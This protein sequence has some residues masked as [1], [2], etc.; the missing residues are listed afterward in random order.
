MNNKLSVICFSALFSCSL[1][2]HAKDSI[3]DQK[4]D[5]DTILL[6]ADELK[7]EGVEYT[8]EK[9]PVYGVIGVQAAACKINPQNKN[10][11]YVALASNQKDNPYGSFKY[12]FTIA[13]LDI[14]KQ[15]VVSSYISEIEEDATLR[16]DEGTLWIDT[17]NYRLNE[18]TRAF[19]VE[20][21]SGYIP[22]C[23]EGGL[24]PIRSL[25]LQ[26]G[27]KIRPILSNLMTSSWRYLVEGQ[28]R[29]NSLADESVVPIIKEESLSLSMAETVT[30][31]FKDIIVNRTSMV[32]D[33]DGKEI[34]KNDKVVKESLF[35]DESLKPY[36]YKIQYNGKEYP[37]QN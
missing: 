12:D 20:I 37:I 16:V 10:L 6:V 35:K 3:K 13:I 30:N 24:G 25:Y 14:K 5:K 17:A 21:K 31:G 8:E 26:E 32:V 11:M 7:L 15:S 34:S 1:I 18:K 36:S 22:S 27:K 9:W 29:C 2:S 28:S 23:A 33:A 19:G 4:C